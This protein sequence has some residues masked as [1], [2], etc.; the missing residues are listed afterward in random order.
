MRVLT[1]ST[2]VLIIVNVVE[3][4]TFQ[5][6]NCRASRKKLSFPATST[7]SERAFS[8]YDLVDAVNRSK[9]FDNR[10]KNG[11]LQKI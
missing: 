2:V 10:K 5:L 1:V 8:I 3:S 7:S 4:K 11:S 6:F 9:F